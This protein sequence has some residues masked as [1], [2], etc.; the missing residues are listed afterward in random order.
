MHLDSFEFNS[1]DMYE[2]YGIRVVYHDP[3][4]PELRE[5]KQTIPGR[6]GAYDFGARYYNERTVTFDCDSRAGLDRG[7]LRELALLLSRKGRIRLGDEPDKYY[8]GRLYKQIPFSSIGI[9][10]EFSLAFVCEPFAYSETKTISG[11]ENLAIS[12][13]GTEEAPTFITIRNVGDTPITG[14][15]IRI[16]ERSDLT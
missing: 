10:Q 4:L 2:R 6:H 5:R 13:R 11:A 1:V 9:G 7:Q 14:I 12:Y 8:I 16:K 3:L 15:Q